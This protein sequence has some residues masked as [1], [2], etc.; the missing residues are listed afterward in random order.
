MVALAV[1]I[2]NASDVVAQE[3]SSCLGESEF[4]IVNQTVNFSTAVT[5]CQARDGTLA[6]PFTSTENELSINLSSVFSTT[7]HIWLGS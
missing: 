5:E 4:F 3:D 7:E 6:V 2:F 1:V